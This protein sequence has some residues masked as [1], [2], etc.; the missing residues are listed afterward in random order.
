MTSS[1][2]LMSK[3]KREGKAFMRPIRVMH[4]TDTLQAAGKER[5]AMNLAN[6]LPRNRYQSYLCTTRSEGP[7]AHLL[8][9]D[10]GRLR[11]ARQRRFELSA[12]YR[13]VAFNRAQ[14]IH[15][16]HAHEHSLFIAGLASLFPPYPCVV[17]HDH[18]G[19]HGQKE[20]SVRLYRL[21]TMR[22]RGIITVSESLA[23]WSRSKL[24]VPSEHVWYLPNFVAATEHERTPRVLPGVPGAR[25]VCVANLRPQ[26]DHLTLLRAMARVIKQVPQA[27]LLL[28]GASRDADYFDLVH[29]EIAQQQ[30]QAYVSLL[31]DCPDVP[32]IL[33][34]CSIGVLS[35]AD[36]GFPLALLEYGMAGLP[37][38]ATAVGQCAEVLDEGR[39]GIL[40][41]PG[42][43]GQ[44]AEALLALLQSPAQRT[45]LGKQLHQRVQAVYSPDHIMERI[46]Q[47]YD[48][49]L[50]S[51]QGGVKPPLS[52]S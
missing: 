23:E 27:Q 14:Q 15:I 34:E 49:I 51:A 48:T 1:A 3:A 7:L 12:L 24:R 36:E 43:P 16:L 47:I 28:V 37:T 6:L 30:L 2:Y 26:K 50:R 42:A 19:M 45:V 40:V 41:P 11:L 13:L 4:I 29:R 25:I 39:A 21:G 5:V 10:V 32:A 20:R 9:K 33:Q 22:A 52:G 44:L 38:V 46:C 17:W 31:G 8:R 35:S 18:Y